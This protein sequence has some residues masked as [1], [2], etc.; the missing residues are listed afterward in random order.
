M[1][2]ALR[3]DLAPPRVATAFNIRVL[4]ISL[5]VDEPEGYRRD[6][7][8]WAVERMW[9]AGIAVVAA[10]G[11][12]GADARG[13]RPA[14]RRPVRDRRRRHRR[15]TAPPTRP[16][17]RSPTTP[18][19]DE[20]RPPDVVAP[21]TGIVSLR[22]PGSTLDTEFPAARVGD[23][24]FRGSGTSQAAAVV[25]GLERAADRPAPRA[26]ARPAQGCCCARGA[27]DLAAPA[28]DRRRRPRR[29]RRS[30]AALPVP[31]ADEARQAGAPAILD[32]VAAVRAGAR[33]RGARRRDGER[34][35]A[36]TRSWPA[37]SSGPAAA[38]P[39]AAGRA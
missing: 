16:T 38:G 24:F 17:T 12:N 29:R 33:A 14:R 31:S 35:A 5:G 18:A 19:A 34:R 23:G 8:A 6:P 37:T 11:N 3:L 1:L 32:L 9:D 7:L 10:A 13:A 36:S 30:L 4:N 26:H 2:R 27:V 39:A 15:A 20:R 25:S 28:A 22:V 21:G